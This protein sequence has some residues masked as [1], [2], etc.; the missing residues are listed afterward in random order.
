MGGGDI[1]LMAI[2]GMVIGWQMSIISIFLSAFLA[3]P[4]SLI[5]LKFKKNHEIPYGPFLSLAALL[6]YI[7]HIDINII[8]S[9]ILR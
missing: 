3:L 1:K 8:F 2:F 5:V 9:W 4:V 7:S 6:I